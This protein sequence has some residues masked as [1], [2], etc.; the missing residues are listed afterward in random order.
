[1]ELL[2]HIA[3]GVLQGHLGLLRSQ[4]EAPVGGP[5]DALLE[6]GI[7][8]QGGIQLDGHGIGNFVIG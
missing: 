4:P 2:G 8:R 7:L 3:Q 5:A 6:G 1:M